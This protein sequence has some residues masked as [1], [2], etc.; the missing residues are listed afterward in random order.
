MNVWDN[1]ETAGERVL[2][3]AADSS[4]KVVTAKYGGLIAFY[5][6]FY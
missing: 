4:T 3:T 5:L 1:L 2:R 6:Y